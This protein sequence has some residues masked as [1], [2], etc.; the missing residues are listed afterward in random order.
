MTTLKLRDE[1]TALQAG[2]CDARLWYVT[3]NTDPAPH[4]FLQLVFK[5]IYA[6]T[7]PNLCWQQAMMAAVYHLNVGLSHKGSNKFS[8]AIASSCTYAPPPDT[9]TK[10]CDGCSRQLGNLQG[11]PTPGPE[12]ERLERPRQTHCR[13]WYFRALYCST[14]ESK[15]DE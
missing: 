12:R 6:L 4:G 7:F 14:T 11:Q 15:L 2:R 10:P 5:L 3:S 8:P 13:C 9:R 1:P